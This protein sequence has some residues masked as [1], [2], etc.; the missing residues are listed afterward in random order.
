MLRLDSPQVTLISSNLF[1]IENIYCSHPKKFMKVEEHTHL[2]LKQ[3]FNSGTVFFFIF[4][5]FL[6]WL[7]CLI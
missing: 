5:L 2:F 1:F 3:N 6:D 4:V 7:L